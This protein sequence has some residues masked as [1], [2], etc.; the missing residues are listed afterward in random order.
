MGDVLGLQKANRTV[1]AIL[2]GFCQGGNTYSGRASY[3]AELAEITRST[4]YLTYSNLEEL[5]YIERYGEPT[6]ISLTKK[7]FDLISGA[8]I[9][10]KV[11]ENRTGGVRKS[12]KGCPK[13]GQEV[14]ENRTAIIRNSNKEYNNINNKVVVESEEVKPTSL[15]AHR[16]TAQPLPEFSAT[17]TAEK[18]TILQKQANQY[19]AQLIA[20]EV[21]VELLR[22]NNRI[23]N[24]PLTMEQLK[25]HLTRFCKY[26]VETAQKGWHR[27]DDFRHNFSLFLPTSIARAKEEGGAVYVRPETNTY[28]RPNTQP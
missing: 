24:H 4:L 21:Q 11:S 14:S 3:I 1:F 12:D 22:K 7:V 15:P 10:L 5:G 8:G 25:F 9:K 6:Q 20:D 13:I 23:G 18:I 19:Y 16:I 2:W 17:T 26:K 27:Y 28:K